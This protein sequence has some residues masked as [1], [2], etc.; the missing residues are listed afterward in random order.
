ML[1]SP[2]LRFTL[3]KGSY[4][5]Q[6]SYDLYLCLHHPHEILQGVRAIEVQAQECSISTTLRTPNTRRRGALDAGKGTT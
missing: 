5:L 3:G 4:N 6:G 1:L 2:W